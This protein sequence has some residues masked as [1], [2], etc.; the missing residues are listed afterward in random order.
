MRAQR[1][2][3]HTN[4][5]LTDVDTLRETS[6]ETG[7]FPCRPTV[8]KPFRDL[9]DILAFMNDISEAERAIGLAALVK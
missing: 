6:P 4:T 2:P 8:S 5:K 1:K 9:H 7:L 3:S